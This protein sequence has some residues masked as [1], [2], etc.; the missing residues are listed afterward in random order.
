CYWAHGTRLP[1][2]SEASEWIGREQPT[3]IALA[4]SGRPPKHCPKDPQFYFRRPSTY[5]FASLPIWKTDP[6]LEPLGGVGSGVGLRQVTNVA[7]IAEEGRKHF[8]VRLLLLPSTC[9]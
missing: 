8:N 3:T 2:P 6:A 4:N 1:Q 9:R 5:R 7:I